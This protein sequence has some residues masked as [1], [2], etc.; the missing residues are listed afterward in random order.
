MTN[1]KFGAIEDPRM[2]DE[3]DALPTPPVDDGWQASIAEAGNPQPEWYSLHTPNLDM[4][5]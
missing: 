1:P 5:D 2:P 4:E 3:T